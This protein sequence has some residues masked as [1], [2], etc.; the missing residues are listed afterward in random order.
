M[1]EQAAHLAQGASAGPPKVGLGTKFFYGFGSLAFG[2]KDLGFRTLLLLFYNQVV[3][4]PAASVAFAL[5]IATV[6]DAIMDPVVGELSD[7]WRSKWGRRHPFMY[8]A[9]VPSALT[10]I[11]VWFPPMGWS[12]NALLVYLIVTAVILRSLITFYEIPSAA[13]ISELTSDYDQRTSLM[14]FRYLFFFGGGTLLMITTYRVFL[15]PSEDYPVG[16]LN[17]DGYHTY[18][19]VAAVLIL[20]SILAS[21]LGTHKHIPSLHQPPRRTLGLWP[22]LKGMVQA[23]SNKSFLMV[24]GAQLC[25][26]MALG[27]SGS[28]GIYMNTFFWQLSSTQLAIL[29]FD[30]LVSAGL[31]FILT[32]IIGKRFSKRNLCLVFYAGSFIVAIWPMLVH[33]SGL[34]LPVGSPAIVPVLFL[35]TCLYGFMGIGATIL[36]N[37]MIA[38]VVEESQ[39]KTGRRTEG[40]FFAASSFT[41]KAVSGFGVFGAGLILAAVAFPEGVRPDMVERATVHDLALTYIPVVGSLYLIGSIL[42]LNYSIT[43]SSHAANVGAVDESDMADEM[44]KTP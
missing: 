24:A 43:R 28:L 3:G 42:M 41:G 21:S 37:S 22:I 33:I 44:P 13:L 19:L 25:K 38:D 9:A 29:A 30:T 20:V 39:K 40:L 2:I 7:N 6:I 12:E 1:T 32:P 16:Q 35:N 10:F 26:A 18:A 14:S 27:V 15:Q 8:A 5:M 4:L 17:L 11:A 36:A 23:I 34:A 31:A